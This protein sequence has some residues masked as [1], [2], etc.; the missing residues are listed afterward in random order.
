[1]VYVIDLDGTLCTTEGMDYMSAEPKPDAIARVNALHD[2]GHRIVIHTARGSGSG[3]DWTEETRKQLD[4]WGLKYDVL[5][6][7]VKF[8]ADRY[9]DDR[10]EVW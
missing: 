5:R 6:C 3:I 4:G 7:G 2:A 8:P 9:V 1:M 10:A